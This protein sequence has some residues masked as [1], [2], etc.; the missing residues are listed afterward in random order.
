MYLLRHVSGLL[1]PPCL[2]PAFQVYIYIYIS[3]YMYIYIH[4]GC[5]EKP[6]AHA[7]ATRS[8]PKTI[9]RGRRH[10]GVSPL[11]TINNHWL[12]SNNL[13]VFGGFPENQ[14]TSRT[15]STAWTSDGGDPLLG[16]PKSLWLSLGSSSQ[17]Y[18][19]KNKHNWNNEIWL[20]LSTY[21]LLQKLRQPTRALFRRVMRI[22]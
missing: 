5:T 12:L 7:H 1:R 8:V 6:C 14:G 9:N 22:T 21:G 16:A 10:Q 13:I 15:R 20:V 17:F 19:S 11:I 18:G 4:T 3:I 2:T